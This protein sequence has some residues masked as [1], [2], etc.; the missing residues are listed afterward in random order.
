[1]EKTNTVSRYA[2]DARDEEKF[3]GW[4]EQREE[5]MQHRVELWSLVGHTM[6][7]F[8]S[9]RSNY[10][11]SSFSPP[12]LSLSLSFSRLWCSIHP[13]RTESFCS[14]RFLRRCS[15]NPRQDRALVRSRNS[16]VPLY[17]LHTLLASPLVSVGVPRPRASLTLTFRPLYLLNHVPSVYRRLPIFR[18]ILRLCVR[19][20][21]YWQRWNAFLLRRSE[22][23][24][25]SSSRIISK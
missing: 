18:R 4:C 9:D 5:R 20:N 13:A 21:C 12:P 10:S 7:K 6:Q 15:I 14:A 2:K 3:G 17:R 19:G 24:N 8:V 25:Q 1:M 11:P 23:Y 22:H 16:F